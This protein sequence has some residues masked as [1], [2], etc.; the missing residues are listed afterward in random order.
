MKIL[1]FF[2]FAVIFTLSCSNIQAAGRSVKADNSKELREMLEK[3]SNS[4]RVLNKMQHE[5]INW[6]DELKLSEQQKVVLIK[7][8]QESHRQ[9]DEQIRVIK[10]AHA[11]IDKIYRGDNDKIR[12]IL[13]PQQQLKF[14]RA[15]YKWKK[16]HGEKNLGEKPALKRMKNY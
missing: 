4:L 5:R 12:K 1:K 13:T 9:V 15:L 2:L 6:D 3:E 10:G 16:S 11:E 7:M 8:M 14:D